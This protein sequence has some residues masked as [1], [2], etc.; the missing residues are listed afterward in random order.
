MEIFAFILVLAAL[1]VVQS[2]MVYRQG[3]AFM[4]RINELRRMGRVAIGVGYNRFR[5]RT[6]VVVVANRDDRVVRVERL[7]G[8]TIFAKTRP[9]DR[10]AGLPLTEV[11]AVAEANHA[12]VQILA[13]LKQAVEALLADDTKR[14][15][16]GEEE[17]TSPG[18]APAPREDE[19]GMP[20]ADAI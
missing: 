6:F 20:I 17:S 10:Y 19:R 13:G 11:L 15:N 18:P 12:P 1:W 5:L 7:S 8:L 3:K 14:G 9:I 16:A 4:R 2:V